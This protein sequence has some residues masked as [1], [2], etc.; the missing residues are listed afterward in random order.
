MPAIIQLGAI[1][2]GTASQPRAGHE[3][4]PER[5]REGKPL[6]RR[7]YG[8]CPGLQ[9][10]AV[11]R[12][13][14]RRRR[15]AAPFCCE[16]ESKSYGCR[17]GAH[18]T[19]SSQISDSEARAQE[20]TSSGSDHAGPFDTATPMT[21]PGD[22][23]QNAAREQP[24]AP[25]FCWDNSFAKQLPDFYVTCD[26]MDSPDPQ[27]MQF[28]RS[29]SEEL[30]IDD[31]VLDDRVAAKVFSGAE[32]PPGAEPL[33]QA[34]AGHQFGGFVPQLGDGRALLLGELIDRQGRR[35]DVA[36]KGSG[37]TPFSRGGD[38]KAA[39][40]PVLREYLIGEAMHALGI[41]TTRAL[42]AV[43]TG[44]WVHRG[45]K[46]PGAILTR[47]AASH[48]RVGTFE[49]FAARRRIDQVRELAEYV[50]DRHDPEL[51]GEPNRYLL[52]LENVADRQAS[53]V[54]QWMLVGFIHGVMNTDNM[55]LSGETIDYGPCAFM[56]S[57][58]PQT[59]FSSIDVG[60]RYA[61]ENQ[62]A[63]ARWN[64]GSLR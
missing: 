54:A 56:E 38:G 11:R 30:G 44:G 9:R 61:Y 37:P 41:P 8:R 58:R 1:T 33:A 45:R 16:N 57:F 32:L 46:L 26:P 24:P 48:I 10:Q 31:T 25:R 12:N 42:A 14:P 21:H 50:I 62:P 47:I 15:R 23:S 49:F 52:L 6:V 5:G 17:P 64:L 39:V 40:G 13:R 18:L 36:L 2:A 59:A 60:G 28:N 43:R 19:L 35:R 3:I 63:I 20:G 22:P 53:L 27:L 7:L 29:L 51:R 34:Y 55:A 4:G